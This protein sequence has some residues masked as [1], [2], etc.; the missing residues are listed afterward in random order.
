MTPEQFLKFAQLLPE[1]LLLLFSA[2]PTKTWLIDVLANL[3]PILQRKYLVT[4]DLVP[5]VVR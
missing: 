4:F 2:N 5:K 1:P 3:S